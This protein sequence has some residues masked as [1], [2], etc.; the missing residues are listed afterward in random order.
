[1]NL[2]GLVSRN[3]APWYKIHDIWA[4][5]LE[6]FNYPVQCIS[7][8]KK[9]RRRRRRGSKTT[10]LLSAKKENDIFAHRASLTRLPLSAITLDSRE[11]KQTRRRRRRERH[12]KM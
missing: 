5:A 8:K 4:C 10:C 6:I 11:L 12:L 7:L 2:A 3:S 1:M 9:R